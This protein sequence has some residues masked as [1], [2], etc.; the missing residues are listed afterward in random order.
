MQNEDFDQMIR[1]L[2]AP[3]DGDVLQVLY[4]R[5]STGAVVPFIGAPMAEDDWEKIDAIGRGEFVQIEGVYEDDPEDWDHEPR[6]TKRCY[7]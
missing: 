2:L 3:E 5:L 6:D 1:P 7:Q 4:L